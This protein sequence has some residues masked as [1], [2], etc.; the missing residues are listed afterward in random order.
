MNVVFSDE[1]MRM[2]KQLVVKS[3]TRTRVVAGGEQCTLL[4][5]VIK[6]LDVVFELLKNR[7]EPYVLH[8]LT[9][10]LNTAVAVMYL[11]LGPRAMTLTQHCDT[12]LVRPRYMNMRQRARQV[13]DGSPFNP[14]TFV[15]GA[16]REEVFKHEK[17]DRN[18][19]YLMITD[20]M[21]PDARGSQTLFPGH[22]CV[23]EK[24]PSGN[25]NLFQSYINQYDLRQYYHKNAQSFNVPSTLIVRI[26]DELDN[27]LRNDGVWT[28]STT[29]LWYDFT[30]VN[31]Q[32]FEGLKFGGNVH[33]CYRRVRATDCTNHLKKLLNAKDTSRLSRDTWGPAVDALKLDLGVEK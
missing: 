17:R 30:H 18:L 10:C 21:L 20:A 28:S 7:V 11:F 16:C 9:K 19:Y 6:H 25:F 2:T 31:A 12:H 13:N 23:L 29:R 8:N 14:S 32:D 24:L 5:T 4:V 33:F 22:V 27:I 15:L 3:T 26:F 1:C